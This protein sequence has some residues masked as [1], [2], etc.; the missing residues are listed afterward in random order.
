[1]STYTPPIK[2]PRIVEGGERSTSS[3][4]DAGAKRRRE[5]LVKAHTEDSKGSPPIVLASETK[6]FSTPDHGPAL[7]NM[8]PRLLV[9]VPT[10]E[11]EEGGGAKGD[12]SEVGESSV[13]IVPPRRSSSSIGQVP[14][15][16]L[17]DGGELEEGLHSGKLLEPRAMSSPGATSLPPEMLF[18]AIPESTGESGEHEPPT[19][20]D[21]AGSCNNILEGDDG[22]RSAPTTKTR[23]A[24][25]A[26]KDPPVGVSSAGDGGSGQEVEGRAVEEDS[27]IVNV[28]AKSTSPEPVPD[29]ST[30]DDTNLAIASKDKTKATANTTGTST[31][32]SK[33]TSPEI[34]DGAEGKE[35]G[36]GH[37]KAK[38]W[39]DIFHWKSQTVDRRRAKSMHGRKA[40][41]APADLIL[42]NKAFAKDSLTPEPQV[43][44][45]KLLCRS[46][47]DTSNLR[48]KAETAKSTRSVEIDG[49]SVRGS[50]LHRSL[51]DSNIPFLISAEKPGASPS[52]SLLNS[53][54]LDDTNLQTQR[55]HISLRR[56]V[57]SGATSSQARD[58]NVEESMHDKVL[59]DQFSASIIPLSHDGIPKVTSPARHLPLMRTKLHRSATVA[60]ENLDE[61]NKRVPLLA[62]DTERD[63]VSK[64]PPSMVLSPT[65]PVQSSVLSASP[66]GVGWTPVI[67]AVIW[68]RMLRILGDINEIQDP[69]IHSEAMVCLQD[70]WKAL[71]NVSLLLVAC[72]Y[73]VHVHLHKCMVMIVCV[74]M[75]YYQNCLSRSPFLPSSLPLSLLSFPPLNHTDCSQLWHCLGCSANALSS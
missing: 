52:S 38:R 57:S 73:I 75:Y 72:I 11:E 18:D 2:H 32:S 40:P 70:T 20:D 22:K 60:E 25:S 56:V 28:H 65:S 46:D 37:S 49:A 35:G 29:A 27:V 8:Q 12:S 51:S 31:R 64:S 15:R 66:Q 74:F 62:E 59:D 6:R 47:S 71:S 67:A 41:V 1:M 53:N 50:P 69:Y 5:R 26:V 45:K 21:T 63:I 61:T 7:R 9:K 33:T 48:S 54:A 34:V 24:E 39:N 23:S 13:T 58:R 4:G 36:K 16:K 14:T 55:S 44:P 42:T 30:S 10:I 43:I 3:V 19:N 17:S 68:C